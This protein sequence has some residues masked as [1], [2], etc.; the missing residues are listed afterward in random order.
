M[1]RII[2]SILF[3]LNFLVLV[4]QSQNEIIK[5]KEV[6]QK[7]L[8]HLIVTKID[9]IRKSKSCKQ[10]ANDS[11]LYVV[12]AF[13]AKYLSEINKAGHSQLNDSTKTP[14]MRLKYFG[15]SKYMSYEMVNSVYVHRPMTVKLDPNSNEKSKITLTTYN[16]VANFVANQWLIDDD[17]K[18]HFVNPKYNVIGLAAVTNP[19]N[20]GIKV[21]AFL[22]RPFL[23]YQFKENK[24]MFPYSTYQSH[25]KIASFN[26]IQSTYIADRPY[27]IKETTQNKCT[28]C[29]PIFENIKFR[30][31]TKGKKVYLVSSE[32]QNSEALSKF[33]AS[34]KNG[35]ILET[36]EYEEYHP[37]NPTYYEKPTRRNGKYIYNGE[38][39]APAMGGAELVS[40][41]NPDKGTLK[42]Y[43]GEAPKIK[44]MFEYNVYIVYKSLICGL[45]RFTDP[46]GNS[47]A[48]YEQ[49]PLDFVHGEAPKDT[50]FSPKLESLT[51]KLAYKNNA[52]EI[53]QT[54]KKDIETFDK[55]HP[56]KEVKELV[57]AV[58]VPISEVSADQKLSIENQVKNLENELHKLVP[59]VK[60]T[61]QKTENLAVFQEYYKNSKDTIRKKMDLE[62]FKKLLKDPKEFKAHKSLL[63]KSWQATADYGTGKDSLSY[64]HL[65]YYNQLLRLDTAKTL[66]E[67]EISYAKEVQR[68]F[69][70][71]LVANDLSLPSDC[72]KV[73]APKN[74]ALTSFNTN[75]W[76]NYYNTH[77]EIS[78]DTLALIYAPIKA[79]FELKNASLV[80]KTNFLKFSSNQ[81]S[82]KVYD[83][84]FRSNVLLQNLKEIKPLLKAEDYTH[85]DNM[86]EVKLTYYYSCNSKAA[87]LFEEN[88]DSLF[89]KYKDAEEKQL[90]LARTLAFYN[91]TEEVNELLNPYVGESSDNFKMIVL[92]NKINQ[93]Y[94]D[95]FGKVPQTYMDQL[96]KSFDN[97]GK[98]RWC[99]Q[100]VGPG[101]IS[102][103]IFDYLPLYHKYCD[104]C[105]P[106]N[107]P[108]TK[109]GY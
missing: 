93:E 45:E 59:S 66:T 18:E 30:I 91:R 35:F 102:F 55:K 49:M 64:Y 104:E 85:L 43:L 92:Y 6:N 44:T 52:F 38:I 11:S 106:Y 83:F 36:I 72:Q 24:E 88:I 87:K 39:Q 62:G 5:V 103:Q 53:P 10:L 89:A 41:Y 77:T 74:L 99:E 56:T 32:I 101:N 20:D 105:A 27:K 96:I 54:I 79:K 21:V 23:S 107:N 90:P 33:L 7:Y 67:K 42:I 26:D 14:D 98:E 8:E 61:I 60:I 57:L 31:E 95:V 70:N 15:V 75:Q 25:E 81:M 48:L 37:G 28:K 51:Y 40:A 80:D 82:D 47:M 84:A 29:T 46:V 108:A 71:Y 1:K 109:L 73:V 65:A 58:N 9:S 78:E 94:V 12:S 100:F 3:S 4:A 16:D 63:D 2:I 19:L 97:L 17:V 68:K 22:G 13:H 76:I 50:L 34:S 86:L 69:F